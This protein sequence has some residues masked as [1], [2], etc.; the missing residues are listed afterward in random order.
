VMLDDIALRICPT[1]SV[2]LFFGLQWNVN[3]G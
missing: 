1:V 3:L 2:I